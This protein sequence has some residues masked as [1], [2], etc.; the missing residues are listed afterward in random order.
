MKKILTIVILFLLSQLNTVAQTTYY[1][2]GGSASA[3]SFPTASNWNTNI[4]G[5]GTTR[6]V[7]ATT[8]ILIIDGTNLGGATPNTS[9]TAVIKI[10]GTSASMSIAQLQIVGGV[11]VVF[12]RVT[13]GSPTILINGNGNNDNDFFVDTACSLTIKGTIDSAYV[14]VK[15]AAAA[16]GLVKGSIS[17]ENWASNLTVLNT[18]A[19]GSLF[20]ENGSTCSV[21]TPYTG[22]YPFGPT[23]AAANAI[24]F[25]AGS[26]LVYKGGNSIFT[27]SSTFVPIVFKKGSTCRFE[28]SINS[29]V[30]ATASD[31]FS[32]KYY[33]N[34]IITNSAKVKA[35]NFYN[36]D[37][38]TIDTGAAFILKKTGF[39]PISGNIINN[40]LLRADT[41]FTS[42]NLVLKG[43]DPQSI[44]GIGVY[45]SL[46]TLSV[47]AVSDVTL[48]TDL[49]LFSGSNSIIAGKVNFQ[50]HTI[51]GSSPIQTRYTIPSPNITVT[52]SVIGSYS[53]SLDPSVYSSSNNLYGIAV[54]ALVT[55]IGIPNNTVI[56]GTS[57]GT[58]TITV[59][60][61]VTS[62][63][64]SVQVSSFV[65]QLRT[66]NTGGINGSMLVSSVSLSDST[67]YIFDATTPSPFYT[68]VNTNCRNL[69][70]NANATTNRSIIV[71]GKLTLNNSILTINLNDT[72]R[73]A[74]GN[75]VEAST[76]NT[77]NYIFPK[78]DSTTNTFGSFIIDKV[79]TPKLFP[80]GTADK[81]LPALVTPANISSISAYVFTGVTNNGDINGS[82]L[83][84]SDLNSYVNA[85]WSIRQ[86]SGSGDV[87]VKLFWDNTLEG[88]DFDGAP[89]NSIGVKHYENGIWGT[90]AGIGDNTN[91]FASASFAS[92]GAFTIYSSA[93]SPFKFPIINNKVYGDADFSA[94]ASSLN[95][96]KP[97]TYI[98]SNPSVATISSTGIIHIVG[99]GSVSIT[100]SQL[101]DGVYSDTSISQPFVVSKANLRILPNDTFKIKGNPNPSFTATYSSF[102]NGENASVLLTPVVFSS[103]ASVASDT[104]I[105]QIYASGAASNNYNI[106]YDTGKLRVVIPFVFSP[107]ANRTYG[108]ADFIHTAVSLNISQPINYSSSNSAIATI[109]SNG[110]IHIVNAGM[111][112][113]YASQQTDGV[114]PNVLDSI[115]L[116]INKANLTVVVLDTNKLAGYPN[117]AFV[118]NITGFVNGENQSVVLGAPVFSV[119]NILH[120]D[121]TYDVTVSGLQANNYNIQ[122]L[123]GKLKILYC[124][125]F[126]SIDNKTYGDF[127]FVLQASSLN[128]DS[129]ISYAS[130]DSNVATINPVSGLVTIKNAGMTLITA[131]QK[132]S[133]RYPDTSIV[134]KLT[135]LKKDL[136]ITAL[137]TLKLQGQANPD[138]TITYQGFAYNEDTSVL[139]VKPNLLTYATQ[140]STPGYY[141][142]ILNGGSDNNYNLT[143]KNGKLRILP[144]DISAIV[145]QGY[146]NTGVFYANIYSPEIDLVDILIHDLNGKCYGRKNLYLNKGYNTVKIGM[147]VASSG[148]FVATIIG[149]TQKTSKRITVIQ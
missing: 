23:S 104:G 114:F 90:P 83:N 78:T 16:T 108:D 24:V 127:P 33:S 11:S 5:T 55:G 125:I 121:T 85:V 25:N 107:V 139:D 103:T 143:L 136:Q 15:L 8:D 86:L 65:P 6:T 57:T 137:D 19:G 20:F 113:L 111:V 133:G 131:L 66:S 134:Q 28:N 3:S 98:S 115:T 7:A 105:Y 41:G 18:Q 92:Y 44:T 100:A 53:I 122:Y 63:V 80:I 106:S 74:S 72:L 67:D 118:Y 37:N 95:T 94:V 59:S 146:V 73:I 75:D 93:K 116:V 130:S 45:D 36:I 22:S 43:T 76:F 71:N 68:V 2:V 42:S 27:S 58:S 32:G 17:I 54:G 142:L 79:S 120:A 39:S 97:I 140:N 124:F 60:N 123:S 40:G 109:S 31:F 147:H 38:L 117:P 26:T 102:V 48:N 46:G 87:S 30:G 61:V 47:S 132:G 51:A 69:T 91:N 52:A 148:V 88:L 62:N 82:D 64:L 144:I 119:S 126:N 81:Y 89:D 77:S 12:Q 29:T 49:K 101:S 110:L 50:N 84:A 1:W 99:A 112:T 149:K 129:V 135:I 138:F 141:G 10:S 56:I 96:T 145:F 35:D 14:S 13:V 9:R 4:N 128:K 21:N 70:F 34:V